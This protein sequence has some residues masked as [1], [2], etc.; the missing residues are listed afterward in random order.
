MAKYQLVK[1]QIR[2]GAYKETSKVKEA[3]INAL[4]N[5][6]K[7]FKM[8]D[9]ED[10]KTMFSRFSQIVSEMKSLGMVYAYSLQIRKL[11]RSLSK[12]WETKVAILEES[13]LQT[14][15]YDELRGNLMAYEHNH[16]QRYQKD[17]KKKSVAFKAEFLTKEEL[18]MKLT[19]R[20]WHWSLEKLDRCSSNRDKGHSR[21]L[22][23]MSKMILLATIMEDLDIFIK[24]LQN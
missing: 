15:T 5:K 21:S 10:V 7:L 12:A 8:A 11:I 22:D 3:R 9:D 19:M 1:Q 2:C 24:I 6:Y 20:G 13:D 16:I 23:K 18:W 4:I 14:M 17:D